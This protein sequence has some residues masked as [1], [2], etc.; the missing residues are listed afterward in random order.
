MNRVE[1][2]TVLFTRD[3]ITDEDLNNFGCDGWKLSAILPVESNPFAIMGVFYREVVEEGLNAKIRNKLSPIQTLVD[4]CKLADEGK[5]LPSLLI[6][7]I[8]KNAIRE[9]EK[10]IEFLTHIGEN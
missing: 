7:D 6:Q 10:S 2:Q 5:I 9:T 3:C 4:I 8:V 1:Y